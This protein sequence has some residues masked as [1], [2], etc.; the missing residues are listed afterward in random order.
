[1]GDLI[2]KRSNVMLKMLL[3]GETWTTITIHQKGFDQFSTVD[4]YESAVK[5]KSVIRE[6]GC[7]VAHIAAHRIEYDFP[8]TVEEMKLYDVVVFS[9]IGSNSFL[10]PRSVFIDSKPDINRLE[11]VR[12][13]VKAGGGF[14]MIG[15]YMSFS[16]IE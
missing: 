12:D 14:A 15:G 6:Q 3:V 7:D 13:Y 8:R 2:S 5:F 4:Y 16:G 9:D 10:L 11:L 1:M